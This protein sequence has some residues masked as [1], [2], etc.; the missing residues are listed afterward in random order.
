MSSQ[1]VLPEAQGKEDRLFSLGFRFGKAS[2]HTSRTM[3]LDELSTI[4]AVCPP[5]STKDDYFRAIIEDNLLGKTTLTARKLTA[6]RLTGLYSLD[7]N[8]CLFR[9]MRHFLVMA[10]EGHPVLALLCAV[11]RDTLLRSSL[12]RILQMKHGEQLNGADMVIY[13]ETQSPGRFSQATVKSTA[14]NIN[15]TWTQA[16]Y[17]SGRIRKI[18]TQPVITPAAVT[19]ALLLAYLEGA[20]AQRLFDSY[21]VRLLDISK[22]KVH[23][24]AIAASQNGWLNYRRAGEVIDIRFPD[25]LN[26]H[27][28]ELLS[29]QA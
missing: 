2:V 3:M 7:G 4:I 19:Y 6:E 26:A 27:E 20:R 5:E 21:W 22:D 23:D 16:G 24:L 13:L 14:Q 29:E 8:T 18:R 1:L 10:G 17:L 11:A 28:Q 25:L 12:E 9:V 15:S